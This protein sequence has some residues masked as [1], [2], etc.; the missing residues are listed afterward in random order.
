VYTLAQRLVNPKGEH[1]KKVT[2]VLIGIY[3]LAGLAWQYQ[4]L[5]DAVWAMISSHKRIAGV[6]TV[7][8]GIVALKHNP[9]SEQSQQ[10]A[11]SQQ[12]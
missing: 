3:T 5:Q 9:L 4:P 2:K 7:I 6:L 11:Q 1:M 8:G 10:N 12:Q